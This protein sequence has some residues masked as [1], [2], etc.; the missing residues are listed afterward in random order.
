MSRRHWFLLNLLWGVYPPGGYP[1]TGIVSGKDTQRQLQSTCPK[2][3]TIIKE[4]S[5]R[6]NQFQKTGEL[7]GVRLG[8]M[9]YQD[10]L[11][12][13][14]YTYGKSVDKNKTILFTSLGN[15]EPVITHKDLGLKYEHSLDS[16]ASDQTINLESREG[17]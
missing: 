7:Q 9:P 14:S 10:T 17:K 2:G 13:C 11:R 5:L 1:G 16:Q 8:L 4:S 3:N 15:Q 12:A 6:L